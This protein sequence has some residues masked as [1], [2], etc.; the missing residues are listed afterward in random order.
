M[1]QRH[2][3]DPD[4]GACLAHGGSVRARLALGDRGI[5]HGGIRG[6]SRCLPTSPSSQCASRPELCSGSTSSRPVQ[7]LPGPFGARDLFFLEPTLLAACL[8]A[9]AWRRRPVGPA[10]WPGLLTIRCVPFS[11]RL[12]LHPRLPSDSHIFTDTDCD[13]R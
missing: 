1:R 2:A 12:W 4:R 13:N 8:R 11:T 5:G 6:G 7:T 3:P 10:G 9:T